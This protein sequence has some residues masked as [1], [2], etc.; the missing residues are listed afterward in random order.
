[1]RRKRTLPRRLLVAVVVVAAAAAAV[2]GLWIGAPPTVS[3]AAERPA[4]GP[5]TVVE[6][7]FLAGPDGLDEVRLELSQGDR[8]IVLATGEHQPRPPWKLWAPAVHEDRL[9]AD[10]GWRHLEGLS[11]GEAVLRA[12]ATRAG[13]WL[14]SPPPVIE[15]LRL[16]VKMRPPGLMVLSTQHYPA[17]GGSDLVVY[18]LGAGAVRDGVVV[19]DLWF[20]GHDVPGATS[21]SR[22]ALYAVP[23]DHADVDRIRLVTEDDAGNRAEVAFVDRLKERPASRDT[24]RLDGAFLERVVPEILVRSGLPDSGDRLADYL[25]INGELRRR[26]G[27]RLTE[28]AASSAP[29]PL[30]RAP[31]LPL[32]NAKVMS[33]F[34]DRRTYLYEGRE[35]DRQVH[36]G[37]DLASVR[38][39]EVPAANDGRVALARYLGIYGNAVVVDHGTGLMS[40]YGHLSSIAV[41]EGDQVA[42]GET[43][44]RTGVTGL[45]G[46]DHLHFT[47]LIGGVAVDAREWWDPRWIETRIAARLGSG[48]VFQP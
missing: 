48:F 15:E 10:A 39:A 2:S 43:L 21:G 35:V 9:H 29:E 41:D 22:F 37:Y 44:G 4:I 24:L 27:A 18:S 11:E 13:T 3:L 31:F 5:S 7:Q 36:L 34:A 23:F 30:W 47:T 28:L 14:R 46:G 42:R 26:N 1:M 8:T 17:Q 16:T 6:G 38:R 20:P 25:G 32:P 19:G 45:A 12:V 33:P 40:L